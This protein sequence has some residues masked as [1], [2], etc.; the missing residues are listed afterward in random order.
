MADWI[1]FLD[2]G[3]KSVLAYDRGYAVE[4]RVGAFS[5][6]LRVGVAGVRR[7]GSAAV[8]VCVCVCVCARARARVCVFVI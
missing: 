5:V 8:C 7:C 6:R 4:V 1:S 3:V 2:L